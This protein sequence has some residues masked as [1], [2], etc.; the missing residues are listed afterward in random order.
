MPYAS[1][2]QPYRICP[3]CGGHLMITAT[4]CPRCGTPLSIPHSKGAAILLAVFLSFWTWL[5]T[6]KRD[7]AKFWWGLGLGILGALTA[8][9]LIGFFIVF[10]VWLWAVIDTATKSDNWYQQYPNPVPR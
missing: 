2:S 1:A 8:F 7:A 5:Y 10:G 4:M 9:F 3:A 6:Y